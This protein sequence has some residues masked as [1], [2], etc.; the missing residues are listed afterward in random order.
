MASIFTPAQLCGMYVC[1]TDF[2]L[3]NRPYRHLRCMSAGRGGRRWQNVISYIGHSL[4]RNGSLHA[5]SS[6]IGPIASPFCIRQY[7]R[8]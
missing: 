2:M 8:K 5:R 3:I 6:E 4:C 1:V 7:Y